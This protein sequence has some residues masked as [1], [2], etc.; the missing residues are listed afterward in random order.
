MLD[1]NLDVVATSRLIILIAKWVCR[2][3]LRF[4]VIFQIG[5]MDD[6]SLRWLTLIHKI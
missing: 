1:L 3:N 6:H 4:R 2:R 5:Q